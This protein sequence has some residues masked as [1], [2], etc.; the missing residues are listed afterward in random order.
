MRWKGRERSENVEDRRGVPTAGLVGGGSVLVIIIAIIAALLGADPR[1]LLDS[2]GQPAQQQG[3]VGQQAPGEDDNTREFIEVVLK[4]TENVWTN[5]IREEVRGGRG[6]RSPRLVIFA[7]STSTGCGQ[8][9][10]AMGPFYCP[11]DQKVYIDPAFFDEMNSRLKA[12]GDFAQAYVLAHEVAHH[13]QNSLGLMDPVNRVRQTGDK[14]AINRASVRLELQAD[15]LAGVWAHHAQK[16]YDILEEGDIAEAMNAA[17]QIG[18]DKLQKMAQGFV[19][20]ER[21]THGTSAQRV[22]WFKEGLR[23]GDLDG[24]KKL[25]EIDYGQL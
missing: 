17:N 24:C 3:R 6:Y 13:V 15:Y 5:L 11:A 18:D 19:V 16:Q 12:P 20:P 23:S 2:V 14:R 7:G 10:S 25:F 1:P 9:N 22:R 8:A 4:D 21:F